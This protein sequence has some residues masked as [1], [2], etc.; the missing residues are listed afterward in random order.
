MNKMIRKLV[1]AIMALVLTAVLAVTVSYAW[2]T[3]SSTPV[4]EGIQISIGGGTTIL[5]AADTTQTVNS[6]VYHYPGK[7]GN[8]LNFKQYDSYDYLNNLSA[9]TPV[10]TADGVHWFLSEYY[11]YNDPEVMNG[12]AVVGQVK[13]IEAFTLDRMLTHANLKKEQG[14]KALQGHYIY[15]DF[16]VV[17]P[18]SDYTLRVSQG[19]DN[20]GSFALE[21]MSP[22]KGEDDSYTLVKATGSAAAYARIGFLANEDTVL[23]DSIMHYQHSSAAVGEYTKLKGTYHDPEDTAWY[24]TGRFTIYEPN[25]DWHVGEQNGTYVMTEPVAYQAGKN[26]SANISSQLTVQ[27]SNTWKGT[28]S[29]GITLEQMFVTWKTGKDLSGMTSE[30]IKKA[31][32]RDYLQGLVAPYVAKGDF[33][34][35]TAALYGCGDS[36]SADQLSSLLQ[37]GAT[38]DVYITTL[39]KNVP[40]RIRMFIWLEGQDIDCTGSANASDF[41]LS[42]ELAGSNQ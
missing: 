20:G 40:Q 31:F 27:L 5:V 30:Q 23:D 22:E 37:A 38:E 11:D 42:I 19:D 25:A 17:S 7:F 9:L 24:R 35:N 28:S 3:I 2:M 29:Q 14:D 13:P 34:A 32:Y 4:A 18:H 15:L 1:A 33:I 26:V 36:A 10:S 12:E 21:L 41:A 16:W 39:E 6:T 8:T